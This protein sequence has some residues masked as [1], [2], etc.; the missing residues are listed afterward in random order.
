M[1]LAD[2][3]PIVVEHGTDG[4]GEIASDLGATVIEGDN[5]G[6]AAGQNLAIANTTSEFVL[7]VNPDA[8]ARAKAVRLG[9]ALLEKHPDVAA[10]QGAILSGRTGEYERSQGRELTP[11]HLFGRA[12]G[13]R[14]AL[15]WA[16]ARAVLLRLSSL[17]DHVERRPATS[18]EVEW[19][20][21]TCLLVRRSALD[22]VGGL[23]DR[24]FLYGEDLDLCRRLRLA[25]WKLVAMPEIWGEH[26][27]GASSHSRWHRELEWW[28]G[29]LRFGAQWWGPR[30][31]F[32]VPTAGIQAVKL[33][34]R[35]P[36]RARSVF[37]ALVSDPW[38]ARRAPPAGDFSG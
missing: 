7:M 3:G 15:R 6:F 5:R 17:R 4:A 35:R 37:S 30:W 21:A 13:V 25:G 33:I 16:P 20:A 32:A 29:T 18:A 14:A 1:E 10:V 12:L 36:T 9:E 38:R 8:T 22:A 28:R 23:D 2:E 26:H 31:W 19:L 27:D 34:V 11:V 24:Y